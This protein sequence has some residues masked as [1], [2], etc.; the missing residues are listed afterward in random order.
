MALAAA[1]VAA[2]T[3][4]EHAARHGDWVGPRETIQDQ[5]VAIELRSAVGAAVGTTPRTAG[6]GAGR[7]G[8]AKPSTAAGVA[9]AAAGVAP[10][11]AGVAPAATGISTA[12]LA[13][14]HAPLEA[15]A[16]AP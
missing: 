11:A 3:V 1:A 2:I 12:A 5:V 9:P 6:V 14:G 15:A 10:A 8:W 7:R 16:L 4:L 13:G